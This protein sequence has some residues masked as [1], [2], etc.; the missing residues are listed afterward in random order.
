[1]RN[2]LPN[3]VLHNATAFFYFLMNIKRTSWQNCEV[4]KNLFF[5]KTCVNIITNEIC[6]NRSVEISLK[7]LEDMLV[8]AFSK[9]WSCCQLFFIGAFRFFYS[10]KITSKFKKLVF[11]RA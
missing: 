5:L 4:F 9:L 2:I 10:H 6:S 7:V 8:V 3:Y 11:D 1:L